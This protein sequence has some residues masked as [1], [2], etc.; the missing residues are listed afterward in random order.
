[1]QSSPVSEERGQQAVEEERDL[2]AELASMEDR[3][4]RARADLENYRKRS[5]R[6]LQRRSR[7]NDEAV[8]REW[9]EVVDSVERAL[10]LAETDSPLAIGLLAVRDQI[11]A[12]LE[13]QGVSR[14]GEKGEPF[15]PERHEA[16]SVIDSEEVDRD[17]VAEVARSGYALGDR[18][19]RPAQVLVARPKER[20]D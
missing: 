5:E 18:V 8:L 20:E 6:E 10:L 2:A 16:I 14:I 4:K 15:D 19:L 17:T 7:E 1:M 11:D 13:R 3:W 9:L 12:V